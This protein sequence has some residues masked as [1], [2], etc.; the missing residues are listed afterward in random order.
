VSLLEMYVNDHVCWILI[1]ILE[2]YVDDHVCFISWSMVEWYFVLKQ[3]F[4]NLIRNL[5]PAGGNSWSFWL[6]HIFGP[7]VESVP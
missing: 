4:Y 7:I 2:V 1:S 3:Y 5:T 6:V